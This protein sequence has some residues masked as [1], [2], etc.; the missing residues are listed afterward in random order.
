MKIGVVIMKDKKILIEMKNIIEDYLDNKC[1]S[2]ETVDKLIHV[3]NLDVIYAPG[4]DMMTTDC[5]YAI[6]HLTETGYETTKVEL[7]YFRDCINGMRIYDVDEKNE[8]IRKTI[9]G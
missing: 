2:V 5:Y 8:L 6:K 7:A 4:T 1:D 9:K 3:I